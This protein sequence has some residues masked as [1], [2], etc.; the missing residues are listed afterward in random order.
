MEYNKIIF[1]TSYRNCFLNFISCWYLV[2]MG[3]RSFRL[4]W[5]LQDWYSYLYLD[6]M[7]LFFY[8][9]MKVGYFFKKTNLFDRIIDMILIQRKKDRPNY[10]NKINIK[11]MLMWMIIFEYWYWIEIIYNNIEAIIML[12]VDPK[13]LLSAWSWRMLNY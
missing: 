6:I 9:W 10:L 4:I 1:C 3:W 8:I 5:G 7:R 11:Y 2:N 12:W 13:I